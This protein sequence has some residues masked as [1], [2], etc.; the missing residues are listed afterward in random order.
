[1][2]SNTEN[3]TT[4]NPEVSVQDQIINEYHQHVLRQGEE[5]A[6]VFAFCEKLGIN[7]ADFYVHFN[8]FEQVADAVWHSIFEK[9]LN[10]LESD[11]EYAELTAREKLLTFYFDFFESMKQYRSYALITLEDALTTMGRTPAGLG[12]LK[13]DFKNWINGLIADGMYTQEVASR[14]KLSDSYDAL[15]WFQFLFLLNF[16]KRDKSRGFEKTDAAIE[17]SVHLSFDLI[18]KNALDSAFDFGKFLFQNL[19]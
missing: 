1:M 12:L 16:W 2:D 4:Q 5:P 11:K 14:S 6:S 13:Q 17:K 15:F 19:K 3:Q 8:S 7:E 10:K 9:V 18:S